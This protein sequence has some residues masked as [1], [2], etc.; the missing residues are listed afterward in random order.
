MTS[1]GSL[2]LPGFFDSLAPARLLDTRV[3]LGATGGAVP[4]GG[5]VAL[6][7]NGRDGVEASRVTAVALTVTA[8]QL[9]NGDR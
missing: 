5:M 8:T 3:G 7:V 1:L 6:Q 2:T 4:A 9:R